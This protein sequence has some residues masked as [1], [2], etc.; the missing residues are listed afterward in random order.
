MIKVNKELR[1]LILMSYWNRPIWVENSLRSIL[2]ASKYHKNWEVAFGDD[3][4]EIPGEPIARKILKDHLDRVKFYNTDMIA[5]DKASRGI[6]IGRLANEA[7]SESRADIFVTLCDDDRLHPRYLG[8]L[9]NW[10][11]R[12]PE[13]S[14]CWSNILLYN[15]STD[16]LA[17]GS[18]S[19]VY[20]SRSGELEPYGKLDGSQVAFRMSS[21]KEKGIWFRDTTK[22]ANHAN[23]LKYNVDGEL[24]KLSY[25]EFGP[26]PQ[27][28]FIAQHK[29][30]HDDQLVMQKEFRMGDYSDIMNFY[31]T[32][33]ARAGKDF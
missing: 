7:I 10:M 4:S 3:G 15:P 24:F 1:I 11:L 5:E 28:G 25:R 30:M 6:C 33:T 16:P 31:R 14:W 26:C 12:N 19:G 32:T 29:G 21:V 27:T 20:N 17:E 13:K 2:D 8:R 9:N 23:P 22:S 18:I